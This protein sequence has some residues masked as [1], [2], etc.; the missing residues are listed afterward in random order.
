MVLVGDDYL[1][2]LFVAHV[3]DLLQRGQTNPTTDFMLLQ[4]AHTLRLLVIEGPGNRLAFRVQPRY[5]TPLWVL[6]PE[7]ISG[8]TPRDELPKIPANVIAYATPITDKTHP[9]GTDGYYHKPYKLEDYLGHSLG[10]LMSRSINARELIKFL[11]NKLGGSHADD[12]LV[13]H[14]KNIE[15]ETLFFLNKNITIFGEGAIFTLFKN[16]AAMIWRSL[17]PL[18]DEIAAAHQIDQ[19]SKSV[20]PSRLG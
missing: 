14:P 19:G 5:K 17:A 6:V 3:D 18:R 2:R 11:A 9:F 13:D 12:E 8:N 16:C 20:P 4:M 15:A 1:D 7:P 10:I